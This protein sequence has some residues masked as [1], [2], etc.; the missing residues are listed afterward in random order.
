VF[1]ALPSWMPA[2]VKTFNQ[3]RKI[4]I[5]PVDPNVMYVSMLVSGIPSI[6]RTLNGGQTWASISDDLNYQGGCVV[7]N[8]H[9]REV[10]KGSMS[11][12]SI[13][14]APPTSGVTTNPSNTKIGY[15]L[16]ENSELVIVG[17][18]P[19]EQFSIFDI[20]GKKVLFFTEKVFISNLHTGIYIVKS[21]EGKWLKFIKK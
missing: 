21:N 4:G 11:G 20:S 13:Y 16:N 9:T 8:P 17:A 10:Y 7:V 3:V 1:A 14:P 6:Y 2:G 5:D 18:N 19:N 15:Y 12:T